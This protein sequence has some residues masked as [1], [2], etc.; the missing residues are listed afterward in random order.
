M[1]EWQPRFWAKVDKNGPV[2]VRRP[3]LGRCWLWAAG[4]SRFGYGHFHIGSAT[5]RAH[6]IA[7]QLLLGDIPEGKELDHLCRVRHCVNPAHLEAV[8]RSENLLR[9]VGPAAT[10]ERNSK[11]SHCKRGHLF[12]ERNTRL[13]PRGLRRCRTCEVREYPCRRSKRNV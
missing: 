6:R 11:K 12:N 4:V 2:S 7:Y 9:G 3:E 8:T 13:T 1:S 5:H 10:R